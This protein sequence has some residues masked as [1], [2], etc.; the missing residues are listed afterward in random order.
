MGEEQP[1]DAGRFGQAH[2]VAAGRMT[3]QGSRG[4]F[5]VG[6]LGVVDEHVTPLGQRHGVGVVLTQPFGSGPDRGGRM[7]AEVGHR[8]PAVGDAVAEA[9]ASFVGDVERGDGEP[10]DRVVARF[11]CVEGPRPA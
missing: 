11:E 5:G 6:V 4:E 2:G 7:I 10:V 8:G 3:P 1:A 9:A